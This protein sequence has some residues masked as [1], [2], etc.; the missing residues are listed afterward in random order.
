M[1]RLTALAAFALPLAAS[2]CWR[3]VVDEDFG[4]VFAC[5]EADGAT[6]FSVRS[7]C[8]TVTCDRDLEGSCAVEAAD[9][10]VDVTSRFS[11]FTATNPGRVCDLGCRALFVSCGALD[12]APGTW[13]L[14]H[15]DRVE[16]IAVPAPPCDD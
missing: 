14:T 7:T 15:G 4:Q 16:A 8:T 1:P 11:W 5:A 10:E 6:R 12:L 2:G 9:G 13:E 3:E